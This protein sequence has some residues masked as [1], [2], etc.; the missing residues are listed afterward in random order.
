[1]RPPLPVL[2]FALASS[3]AAQT[4][5]S[6]AG[7][8]L[9][10]GDSNNVFP[11]GQ[12]TV[13]RYMQIHAD[14]G[15][16]PLVITKL[17]FRINAPTTATTYTGTRTHDIEVY[18]GEGLPTSQSLPSLTYDLNYATPKTT[19]LPRQFVTFGPTGAATVPG[20]SPFSSTME[21]VLATPFV[22][23]GT[24]PLF[25]EVASF[26]STAVGSMAAYDADQSTS[27]TAASTITG[28]GCAPSTSTTLMTHAYTINDTA[29]TLLMN[30]TIT[31]GP[32]NAIALMAL[33][34]T[35]PNVPVP[36]L[37]SNLYTDAVLI[38]FLGLTSGTGA[39]TADVATGAFIL[40]N[41][42][43]GITLYTQAFCLDPG[44][45]FPLQFCA[46]NGRSGTVPAVGTAQVNLVT[47]LWNGV[48]GTTAPTATFATSTVGYGVVVQ[49]SHL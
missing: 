35:N 40:P 47:R 20:P 10:E 38:Q 25:W 30:G 44:S 7:L 15:S 42:A 8:D 43:T 19:V 28:L 34:F 37:C 9:V 26:G 4:I 21:I 33:G 14:L 13:R 31:G 1:M 18:M 17:S 36:G 29:G 39:Y 45:A 24:L 48:G 41:T 6:P 22:Y 12:A 16:T 11:F 32:P 46:S 2:V 23:S 5:V 49:F 3:L 27:T